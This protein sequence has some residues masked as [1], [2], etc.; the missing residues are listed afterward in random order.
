MNVFVTTRGGTS[1][2]VKA[3]RFVYRAGP[4]PLVTGISPAYGP[5]AGGTAVTITGSGFTK[6]TAVKFGGLA[7]KFTVSSVQRSPRRRRKVSRPTILTT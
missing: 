5:T 1:A 6:A 3:D 2:A 4:G 7:A